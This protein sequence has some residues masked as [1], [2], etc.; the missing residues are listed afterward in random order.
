MELETLKLLFDMQQAGR[1]VLEFVA[2]KSEDEYSQDLFFRS[3][4]ERQLF[5]VGE[6]LT[7]LRQRDITIAAQIPDSREIIAF[8]NILAHAY[9][10]VNNHRVWQIIQQRLPH[11]LAAVEALLPIQPQP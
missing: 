3:A 10:T 5:I 11:T 1:H 2:G 9:D 6:A 4:V 8:R 7:Q